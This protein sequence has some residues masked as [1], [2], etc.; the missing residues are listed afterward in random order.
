LVIPILDKFNLR[1]TFYVPLSA[2]AIGSGKSSFI[3][4][5]VHEWR[6]V[7]ETGHELGNHSIF[8]AAVAEKKWVP[9]GYSLEEYSVSRMV[10]E[11]KVANSLLKA[12][13][14]RD[15][16]TYAYPC[17]NPFI[18][19]EGVINRVLKLLGL[20]CTRVKSWADKHI[21]DLGSTKINFSDQLSELFFACRTGGFDDLNNLPPFIE[22]SLRYRIP[23]VSANDV[24][25]TQLKEYTEKCLREG[26]WLVLAFHGVGGGHHLNCDGEVFKHYIQYLSDYHRDKVVT[27]LDGAKA[28][29][30]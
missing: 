11:L 14:G 18:G 15:D 7:A 16:R 8:H 23:S 1:G 29:F 30:G 26:R 24:T 27:V 19:H 20:N 6:K 12:I 21:P 3:G 13:D 17:S 2:G 22:K 10:L 9:E 25:F 4:D 28:R 5:R